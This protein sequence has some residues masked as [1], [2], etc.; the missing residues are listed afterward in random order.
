MEYVDT[1]L[2]ILEILDIG[3]FITESVIGK[4]LS[5]YVGSITRLNIMVIEN[6]QKQVSAKNYCF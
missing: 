2:S 6:F 3:T 5:I 4:A 1:L